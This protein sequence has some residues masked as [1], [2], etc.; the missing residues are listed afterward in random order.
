MN[1]P[2]TH[3]VD[4]DGIGWIVFDDPES[5]ANVFNEATQDALASAIAALASP[6]VKAIVVMS[7]KERIFIAG[8]DLYW[9]ARLRGADEATAFSRVGQSLF[10]LLAASPVPVVCAIQGACAGG[11]FEL[12][13]ACHW[14]LASDSPATRIG[15]P[16][17][18]IGTIPGWGGSVRLP[19]LIGVERALDHIIAAQLVP[20]EKALNT[21]L[22]DE[23]AP[24][25][26][27]R[28]RAKAAALRFAANGLP[29]RRAPPAPASSF[30]SERRGEISQRVRRHLPAVFAAID[31]VEKGLGLPI[32]GALEAEARTFG[33]VTAGETCKNLV[34]AFFLREM[35]KKRSI[36]PWFPGIVSKPAPI[37]KVGVVGAGVMGSGIA[38]WLAARG[39][40][41]VMRD[42]DPKLVERGLGVVQGLFQDAV[43]RGRM[44]EAQAGAAQVRISTT[45]EWEGIA[46][47]DLVIEAIIE[48]I[49]A[50][51]RLF[52]ELA[53]IV[54]PET[55]LA[56]NTS[57][58][59]I[60]EVA[61]HVPNPGRTLGIHFFN[62]VSRMPLV[63]LVVSRKTSAGTADRALAFV[64][65]LGKE[66]VICRSSPGFLVTRVLFFY[67][68]EAVKLWEQGVPTAAIDDALRDFG[69]PMGPMRLIDEVGVDVTDFIFGEMAHYYPQ[70]FARSSACSALLACG[71]KGR[72]NGSA[73]GFYSYSS[74]ESPNDKATRALAAP[75]VPVDIAPA[76]ITDRLMGLMVAEA[77]LCLD[78][79][80]ARTEKDIDFALLA[81][82]GFPSFRGGLMRFANRIAGSPT[83]D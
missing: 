47:C 58:L 45:T 48:D 19:R 13:L 68:N 33:P 79:G 72:K 63:E 51:Q 83:P 32:A 24:T 75:V 80:V 35:A 61:G 40:D 56:S 81:G 38:H 16:E 41:V 62:P 78:E 49:S 57:A 73:A 5:K 21:G 70:R 34:Y 64:K 60:E 4:G 9:L 42:V 7:G 30:F 55:L 3:S 36:E 1:S 77:R 69:W 26:D 53:G 44:S 17:V 29:A 46:D 8:A 12:A 66:P 54:G 11:G 28:Q 82:A 6:A 31:A 23:V 14:R 22:I 65:A 10:Q 39:L 15:L 74:P 59:P 18:G 43:K 52:T 27:L 37:R 2:V 67:L 76:K 20:A 25:A 50:K 71:L